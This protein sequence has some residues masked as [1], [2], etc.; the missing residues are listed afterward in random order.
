M[1]NEIRT[2]GFS[3]TILQYVRNN[4]ELKK[5]FCHLIGPIS[6]V[7]F[8]ERWWQFNITINSGIT[9]WCGYYDENEEIFFENGEIIEAVGLTMV[10][11]RG[12][13]FTVT[14]VSLL[15]LKLTTE[16]RKISEV[17]LVNPRTTVSWI[18]TG[19]EET[20]ATSAFQSILIP[21]DEGIELENDTTCVVGSFAK[22]S[23]EIVMKVEHWF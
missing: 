11:K 12:N 18:F 21:Y 8:D 13:S 1:I 5:V 3:H 6:N 10:K 16:K 23:K 22:R 14:Y 2:K 19:K 9:L 17:I 20:E 7:T 15:D 4:D